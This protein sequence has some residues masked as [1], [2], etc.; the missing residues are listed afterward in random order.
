MSNAHILEYAYANPKR[1]LSVDQNTTALFHF[2][3][4]TVDALGN[5]HFTPHSNMI[6]MD[7]FEGRF[8][9]GSLYIARPCNPLAVFATASGGQYQIASWTGGGS[10]W[11]NTATE[12]G[13]DTAN[14]FYWNYGGL[15]GG[16]QNST[17]PFR[18]PKTP[19]PT[20]GSYNCGTNRRAVG[21]ACYDNYVDSSI[22]LAQTG[23]LNYFT[24]VAGNYYL[25]SGNVRVS[26]YQS[27]AYVKAALFA[28]TNYAHTLLSASGTNIDCDGQYGKPWNNCYILGVE[29]PGMRE[30]GG[31]YSDERWHKLW[32]AIKANTTQTINVEASFANWGTARGTVEWAGIQVEHLNLSST[33]TPNAVALTDAIV[34][35]VRPTPYNY[36]GTFNG[37]NSRLALSNKLFNPSAFTISWWHKRNGRNLNLT[38]RPVMSIDNSAGAAAGDRRRFLVMYE[39]DGYGMDQLAVWAGSE[40]LGTYFKSNW[41]DSLDVWYHYAI[42]FDG[43]TLTMYKNGSIVASGACPVPGPFGV[44]AL[45]IGN[46]STAAHFNGFINEFRIDKVCRSAAE[47]QAWASTTMPFLPKGPTRSANLVTCSSY[48][49]A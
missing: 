47:I 21:I 30:S 16:A 18:N 49:P 10:I 46:W 36:E 40:S 19:L 35:G 38:Y 2:T 44:A 45:Y 48:Y 7:R 5:L 42:T 34:S 8:C 15:T 43:T 27:N 4:D 11:T 25:F 29:P 1:Q 33:N 22:V 17:Y 28:V 39:M 26:N 13:L 20:M 9:P 37:S 14:G 32:F 24:P 41:T 12:K 31:Y 23:N 6:Y 3:H